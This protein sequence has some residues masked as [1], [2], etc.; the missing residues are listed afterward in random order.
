MEII[1]IKMEC[2]FRQIRGLEEK[3]NVCTSEVAASNT[4][5]SLLNKVADHVYIKTVQ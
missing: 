4:I 1:K 3:N 5:S 2:K